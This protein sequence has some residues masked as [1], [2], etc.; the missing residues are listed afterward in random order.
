MCAA[1]PSSACCCLRSSKFGFH[2]KTIGPLSVQFDNPC[3]IKAFTLP[4]SF[5]ASNNICFTEDKCW[6]RPPGSETITFSSYFCFG[7]YDAGLR[8][9]YPTGCPLRWGWRLDS[10]TLA[11][12]SLRQWLQLLRA[13]GPGQL[14]PSWSHGLESSLGNASSVPW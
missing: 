1:S 13:R 2:L 6:K 10:P 8:G 5:K 3:K 7:C 9:C 14:L 11:H 4:F 12:L